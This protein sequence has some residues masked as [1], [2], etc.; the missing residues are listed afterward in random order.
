M[1]RAVYG[2]PSN[3]QMRIPDE[4]LHCVVYIGA[5]KSGGEV[6]E[7]QLRG[8][9]F[10][11]GITSD[12]NPSTQYGYLVT[13][14]HCIVK[15]LETGS[16]YVRLNLKSG[17]CEFVEVGAGAEWLY[18]DDPAS[19]VAVLPFIPNSTIHDY[20]VLSSTMLADAEKMTRHKIGIGD[21]AVIAG[22]FSQHAGKQKNLPIVRFGEIAA[23]PSERLTDSKVGLSYHAY[24]IEARSIGGLS[25]SPVFAFLG[26]DRVSPDGSVNLTQ[27]FLILIGVI[28]GHWEHSEPGIAS[29]AFADELDKI[30]FGIAAVTPVDELSS[31]LFGEVLTSRR[32]LKDEEL[33]GAAS[34][35]LD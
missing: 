12:T 19:D 6:E 18:P 35:V 30:N 2:D 16:V 22:L 1:P 4:I 28:R 27:W 15:A 3:L 10:L 24:L 33:A 8:T 21:H 25:G 23:M 5:R 20:K 7:I 13:A 11:V 31:V 17:G 26:P 34:A 32:K 14:K 29:S 9:G